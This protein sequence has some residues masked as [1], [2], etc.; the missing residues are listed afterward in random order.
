MNEL[1]ADPPIDVRLWLNH[2]VGYLIIRNV[3]DYARSRINKD[4][5]D[6]TRAIA[7]KSIDD[8]VYGVMMMLDGIPTPLQNDRYRVELKNRLSL[9]D[10]SNGG[11]TEIFS[12]DFFEGFCMGYHGWIEGDYGA[13][14]IIVDRP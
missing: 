12:D 14:P 8:A 9:S 7:E 11:E 4:L 2:A 5:S 3:R 13:D 6:S 1:L 10:I